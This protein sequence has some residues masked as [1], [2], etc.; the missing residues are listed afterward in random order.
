MKFI[1]REAIDEDAKDIAG[2]SNQLGYV[3][4]Q[5][6]TLQ[7]LEIIRQNKNE[8]VFVAVDKKEV[9]G[10]AHVFYTTRLESGSF[11]EIG[12]LVVNAD[13]RRTGIGKMLVE[14]AKAWSKSKGVSF[15][16]VRSNVKRQEAHEFYIRLGFKE[17]K[18]Q[19][20]FEID[21]S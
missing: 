10:W 5:P 14:N 13:Y 6:A 12:G 4:S 21:L 3:I 16:R 19:K 15:L 7:N 8:I 20:V 11:C 17:S 18:E 2:L 9:V 1:F